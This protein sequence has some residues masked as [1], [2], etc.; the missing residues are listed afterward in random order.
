MPYNTFLFQTIQFSISTQFSYILPI[1]RT[2]SGATT[3]GSSGLGS[4]NS[5]GVRHI[6]QIS[7]ITEALPLDYSVTYTGNSLEESYPSAE[8][9]FVYFAAPADWSGYLGIL[10]IY[11]IE[12]R[13][14]SLK[15]C[16]KGFQIL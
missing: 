12:R 14:H 3:S 10:F 8:M 15:G 2:L 5:K 7:I 9:Q 13:F 11:W 1:G 16:K 6:P 4:D